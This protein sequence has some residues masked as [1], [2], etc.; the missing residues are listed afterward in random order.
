[1]AIEISPR[2]RISLSPFI[3]IGAVICLGLAVFLL[4]SYF[5]FDFKI[6]KISQE[7]EEKQQ[8]ALPVEQAIQEKEGEIFP[9]KERLNDF[10][11]LLSGHKDLLTVFSFLERICLPNVWFSNFSFDSVQRQISLSGQTDSFTTLEHQIFV[12]NQEPLLV[13]IN[14]S[15]VLVDEQGGINFNFILTLKELSSLN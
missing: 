4:A 11:T 5:Y 3:I 15:E 10:N 2:P 12:L 13:N 6:K 7:L 8:A 9:I 14:I 1:M